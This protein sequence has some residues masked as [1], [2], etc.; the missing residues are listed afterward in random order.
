[1]NTGIDE[2]K[3][4]TAINECKEY[5]NK[6]EK[7]HIKI[8][9]LLLIFTTIFGLFCALN[10]E[11]H[12]E[13]MTITYTPI[14][15]ESAIQHG[16]SSKEIKEVFISDYYLPNNEIEIAV[17]LNNNDVMH[18][19]ELNIN[20][21]MDTSG[22]ISGILFVICSIILL[23]DFYFRFPIRTIARYITNLKEE[24]KYF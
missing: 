15:T 5:L 24:N 6:I 23:T 13:K 10:L 1:M 14:A 8:S 4:N 7:M 17:V 2:I 22:V 21:K 18:I 11:R 9:V 12:K 20:T 3:K 19:T 16:I